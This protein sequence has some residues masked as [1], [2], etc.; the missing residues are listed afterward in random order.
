MAREMN[1][2]VLLIGVILYSVLTGFLSGWEMIALF[3]LTLILPFFFGYNTLKLLWR[4][5]VMLLTALLIFI[6][7]LM[8]KGV[9][10]AASDTSRFLSL[11]TVSGLF[12]LNI[13]LIYLSSS[14]GGILS[15]FFGKRGWKISSYLMM[16]L[17][18]F[19][20]IFS[21]AGEMLTA[22]R[23]RGGSFFKHPVK[24][25]TEYTVSLMKLLFE[26]VLSFQDALY[27]RS[28]TLSSGRTTYPFTKREWIL[29]ALFVLFFTGAVIW[30]KVI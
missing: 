20:I 17:S 4:M 5:K 24:N 1:P 25:L 9:L 14:L 2:V 28:F 16:S 6:F 13:D 27:S 15:V 23:A 22:R 21:S 26:K 18:I 29:L 19:P 7:G 12:V 30:K 10:N 8:S 11:I 3:L